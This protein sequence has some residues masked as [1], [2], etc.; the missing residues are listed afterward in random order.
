MWHDVDTSLLQSKVL[1]GFLAS[2]SGLQFLART[3]TA[4]RNCYG[5]LAES[6]DN[7]L[8]DF[9]ACIFDCERRCLFLT[10]NRFL[11]LGCESIVEGDILCVLYDG[12]LPFVLCAVLSKT[13]TDQQNTAEN[14]YDDPDVDHYLLVGENYVEG[15]MRDEG[16]LAIG[17]GWEFIG[18]IPFEL[19]QEIF[20]RRQTKRRRL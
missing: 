11:G 1:G 9:A 13:G 3:F 20:R 19:V 4:G 14:W 7:C 8:A 16:V 10:L 18:P 12:D 2:N 15:L 5:S 6:G 17:E